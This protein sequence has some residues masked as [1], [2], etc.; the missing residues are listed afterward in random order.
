MSGGGNRLR[1]IHRWVLIAFTLTVVA[2]FATMGLG[3]AAPPAWITY[4]PL[5]PLAVLLLTGLYLFVQPYRARRS[6]AHGVQH[7]CPVHIRSSRACRR[8][9]PSRA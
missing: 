5:A 3:Q 4:A 6:S 9:A 8:W 2:N 1:Q 7:R